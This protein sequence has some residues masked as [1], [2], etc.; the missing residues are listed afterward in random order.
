MKVIIAGGR[1]FNDYALLRMKCDA[2]LAYAK[3]VTVI[4]GEAK[5]ADTLGKKFAK[6]RNYKVESYPANWNL[7]GKGA[8]PIRNEQMA[9]AATHLIAFWDG[10]SRGTADMIQRATTHGLTVR[11]IRY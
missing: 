2:I 1:D 8:G 3:S 4:C 11:V 7:N 9:K 6:A 5:G 10:Q